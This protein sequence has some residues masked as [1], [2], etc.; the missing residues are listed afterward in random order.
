MQHSNGS[1]EGLAEVQERVEQLCKKRHDPAEREFLALRSLVALAKLD[2]PALSDTRAN[3]I[4]LAFRSAAAAEDHRD[5]LML[6]PLRPRCGAEW[7]VD[8]SMAVRTSAPLESLSELGTLVAALLTALRVDPPARGRVFDSMVLACG[9]QDRDAADKIQLQTKRKFEQILHPEHGKLW[10]H[11]EDAPAF[12]H[13]VMIASQRDIARG[14]QEVLA[15]RL[16]ENDAN[17]EQRYKNLAGKIAELHVIMGRLI[18]RVSDG[19]EASVAQAA[20]GNQALLEALRQLEGSIDAGVAAR[21]ADLQAVLDQVAASASSAAAKA[22]GAAQESLHEAVHCLQGL[23]V[24][25]SPSGTSEDAKDTVAFR[26]QV[27]EALTALRKQIGGVDAKVDAA[28]SAI[29]DAV[30]ASRANTKL[31]RTLLS[32]EVASGYPPRIVWVRPKPKERPKTWTGKAAQVAR[33]LNP[34]EWLTEAVLVTFVCPAT[35]RVAECGP[36]GQGFPVTMTKQA[37][38][39]ALPYL[40][41]GLLVLQVA[42]AAGRA[43]GLP[44]PNMVD[45]GEQL[46]AAAREAGAIGDLLGACGKPCHTSRPGFWCCR[47]P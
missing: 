40:K 43:L 34:K 15:Q 2:A 13:V 45:A 27:L 37:V 4:W 7:V 17:N 35:L 32:M 12:R 21:G 10:V 26:E 18:L 19:F 46:S 38:L 47:S 22:R 23:R 36:D 14:G 6:C 44:L 1:V 28:R 20:A 8:D 31:L 3:A 30:V 16:Q 33:K 42:V 41:A 39:Q 25:P 5:Q 11:M 24:G 9:D 29:Q